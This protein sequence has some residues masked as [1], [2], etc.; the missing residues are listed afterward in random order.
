MHL[1]DL[2]L[3]FFFK[4]KKGVGGGGGGIVFCIV[5]VGAGGGVFLSLFFTKINCIR[6]VSQ[7]SVL[8]PEQIF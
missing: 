7:A 1:I 2:F 3:S 5:V 8:I 4:K 6:S